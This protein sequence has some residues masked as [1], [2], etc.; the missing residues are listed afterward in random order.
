[1]NIVKGSVVALGFL[2]AGLAGTALADDKPKAAANPNVAV[3]KDFIASWNDPD[4]A[5]TYLA[6]DS[7]VRMEEDKP[8]II[9]PDAAGKAFKGFLTNGTKLDVKILKTFAQGPVVVNERVDT[10][11]VPGQKGQ[12]FPVVGVFVVKDGKI[13]EWTDYL[14]K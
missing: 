10:L 7:A 6:S 5:V 13:K 9:G 12:S 1:M 8:A 4:K 11:T 3:V 14:N 2:A